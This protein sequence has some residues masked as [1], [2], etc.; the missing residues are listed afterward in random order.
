MSDRRSPD[1]VSVLGFAEHVER[2]L[3]RENVPD[4]SPIDEIFGMEDGQTWSSVETRRGHVEVVAHADS[5]GIGVI[6]VDDRV[7]VSSVA[8]IRNP[9]LGHWRC[10]DGRRPGGLC[11]RHRRKKRKRQDNPRRSREKIFEVHKNAEW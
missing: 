6:R 4:E 3:T 11:W 2:T 8:V 1:A 7:L 9:N 5:V 10:D